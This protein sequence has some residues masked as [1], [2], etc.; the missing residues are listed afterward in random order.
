D[1]SDNSDRRLEALETGACAARETYLDAAEHLSKARVKAGAKLDRA[2]AVELPPLALDKATFQTVFS[3]RDEDNWSAEGWDRVAFHI[4]TNPGSAP[5]PLQKVASGGE[6][7][8]VML[9]LKVALSQN[10]EPASLIFDEVDSGVGGAVADKVGERLARL[11]QDTQVIVVTHSPQVAARA[12]HHWLIV[13]RA[14]GGTNHTTVEALD[15]EH[16]REEIARM[17]A[18]AKIT[19]EARAAADSLLQAAGT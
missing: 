1:N 6:L 18:G 3:R 15:A 5:G 19:D 7:S 4:A 10:R 13:K 9:A 16:R 11:A 14:N 2:M 17:L 8:R 12:G